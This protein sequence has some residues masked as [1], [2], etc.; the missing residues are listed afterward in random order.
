MKAPSCK[1]MVTNAENVSTM[2]CFLFMK[3]TKDVFVVVLAKNLPNC[4]RSKFVANYMLA[5]ILCEDLSMG[6]RAFKYQPDRYCALNAA[7]KRFSV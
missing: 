1:Q 3:C 5:F 7:F 4:M 2:N 6:R